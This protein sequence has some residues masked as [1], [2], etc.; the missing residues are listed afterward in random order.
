M[1]FLEKLYAYDDDRV[2]FCPVQNWFWTDSGKNLVFTGQNWSKLVK[3]GQYWSPLNNK[4]T[5]ITK[6]FYFDLVIYY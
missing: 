2:G 3:A 4:K 1:R 5:Y 6:I